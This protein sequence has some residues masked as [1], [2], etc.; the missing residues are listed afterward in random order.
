LT[1]WPTK[2]ALLESL[3]A[4][5]K[6]ASVPD[7]HF[8]SVPE[9]IGEQKHDPNPP[10]QAFTTNHSFGGS[11]VIP[12]NQWLYTKVQFSQTGYQFWVSKNGYGDTDFL[13]GSFTYDSTTWN[14]LSNAHF[15]FWLGDNYAAGAYFQIAEGNVTAIPEPTSLSFSAAAWA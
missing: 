15:S 5:P 12:A 6:P 3:G 2:G 14:A 4:N 10:Y 8:Q 13:N 9:F 1:A 7:Q 11:E